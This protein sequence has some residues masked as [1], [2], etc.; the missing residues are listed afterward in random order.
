MSSATSMNGTSDEPNGGSL[1]QQAMAVVTAHI[2]DN[3]LKVGD[4]LPGEGQFASDL[5]VS[6]AVMREAFGALAALRLLDVGNGRRARV[7]AID[8]SVMASSLGHAVATAQV[9]MTEVWDVRRTLEMR[10]A[11]L[12][13]QHCSD[14]QAR[15]ITAEAAG[16]RASADALD[17]LTQHD[18]AFHQS[19]ALAG[20]NML[21][22][23]IIRSFEPLMRIAVPSAWRT[24]TTEAQ[25]EQVLQV[26]AEIASAI[27]DRDPE[28]AAKA[29]DR[30]FDTTIGDL[31]HAVE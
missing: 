5:G 2:R 15:S 6:R 20:G 19:I 4:T 28:A 14:E 10:T 26:H 21:F 11:A 1:V 31:L 24:R 23:Q 29:M 3:Q 18:I 22:H 9:S 8:G 17:R 12:A 30:H 7:S 27:S 25:R 13:A 16:M